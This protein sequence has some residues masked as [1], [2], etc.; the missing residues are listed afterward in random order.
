MPVPGRDLGQQRQKRVA[1]VAVLR[2]HPPRLAAEQPVALAVVGPPAGHRVK[3]RRQFLGVHLPVAG[4][5]RDDVDLA[6][7][8][9][10]VP[11]RDR[12]PDPAAPLVLDHDQPP[13]EPR[14][15][16]G[17]H[18]GRAVGRAVVDHDDGIDPP[19]HR[20]QDAP[21]LPLFVVGRH[22]DRDARV[23]VHQSAGR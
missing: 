15:P 11:A 8:G 9:A 14:P 6:P 3:D 21:D 7:Q 12:R 19:G 1:Q 16:L 13:P 2:R 20:L 4:H 10:G 23:T 18:L 17:E 22:D 5:H